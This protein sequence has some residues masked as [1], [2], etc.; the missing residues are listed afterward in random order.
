MDEDGRNSPPP[1]ME[2][3][4][5]EDPLGSTSSEIP[6]ATAAA[7][8]GVAEH[9]EVHVTMNLLSVVPKEKP[10]LN[11]VGDVHAR[12]AIIVVSQWLSDHYILILFYFYTRMTSL[13]IWRRS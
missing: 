13:M 12:I 6:L 10:P 11:V 2:V 9:T 1:S 4:L 3:E 7:A 8:T 5:D